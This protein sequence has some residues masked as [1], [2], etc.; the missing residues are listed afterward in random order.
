MNIYIFYF[1]I[2]C[3][4]CRTKL[5]KIEIILWSQ[6]SPQPLV[7]SVSMF[8]WII[9]K[10]SA[11]VST[12]R[13]ALSAHCERHISRV[14]ADW[15]K[16]LDLKPLHTMRLVCERDRSDRS[17]LALGKI[18]LER[19]LVDTGGHCNSHTQ[20]HQ[21][22]FLP[23]RLES[24]QLDHPP[25]AF[26][27]PPPHTHTPTHAKHTL[28]PAQSVTQHCC[29]LTGREGLIGNRHRNSGCGN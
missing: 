15:D 9:S 2:Y 11:C 13:E 26:G 1:K 23:S 19:S 20:T 3:R 22:H 16:C 5:L 12:W 10:I 17:P 18:A 25:T 21:G 28:T 4:E 29:F 7:S 24:A 27:F 8:M 6:N 14:R